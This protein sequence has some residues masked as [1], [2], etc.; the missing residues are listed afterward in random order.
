MVSCNDGHAANTLKTFSLLYENREYRLISYYNPEDAQTG[1]LPAASKVPMYAG[2]ETDP[3]VLA[4]AKYYKSEN[5]E[6]TLH[7]M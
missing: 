6:R 3:A 5:G 4:T 2:L 7:F 1:I